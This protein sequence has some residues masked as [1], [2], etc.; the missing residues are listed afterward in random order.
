MFEGLADKLQAVFDKLNRRG[1][2]NEQ[3][4]DV[5]LREVRVA[6]LE[7]DVNFKVVKDFL[8][9][10]KVRAVGAEV[11]QS[12]SPGQAVVKIVHDELLQTLGEGASLNLGGPSPRVIMLV[13]LQGAGKT[14]TIAKLAVRLRSNGHKPLMVAADTKRPAAITQ[15]EQLGKQLN[16]TVY[17]EGDKVP[18]P[19]ICQNALKRAIE[20]AYDIV[21]LDTAGRL[22]IDDDMMN[23]VEEIKRRTNPNEVLLV[24]DAMTGQEAVNIADTF[25]KRLG[26]TGLILTKVDGDA[27]G[28]AAISMRAVTGVPIKFLATGEKADAFEQFHP[29]RLAGRILGMGDMMTLIERAQQEFDEEE[30]AKSAERMMGGKFDFEDFLKQI[31][32]VKKLGPLHDLMGML[33]GMRDALKEVS[34]EMTERQMKRTEAIIS[35]MTMKERRDPGLLNASRKR[36]V[37][38]GSGTK[39]E[40]INS[41]INQFKQAQ[42]FMKMLSNSP[43]GRLMG[44]LMG[45]R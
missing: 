17:T 25:N 45:R 14:T 44:G 20:G 3:D 31:R 19:Q 9:R 28:G 27:R 30:T 26:L 18:P 23:E 33:P 21:L 24:A 29:D 15:L 11:H 4:V 1:V 43:R 5:A 38:K 12:L 22:Q 16:V 35:S 40:D 36:R 7:A 37:A 2:L 39:V 13:G 8:A 6:L 32:Q 41:L 34:P 10:V 42:K